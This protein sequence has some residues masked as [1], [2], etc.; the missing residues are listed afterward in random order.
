[1][2]ALERA[3]AAQLA[4]ALAA[5]ADKRERTPSVTPQ[6]SARAQPK[7]ID[8]AA[9]VQIS[10]YHVRFV[11]GRDEAESWSGETETTERTSFKCAGLSDA[12]SGEQA[13]VGRTCVERILTFT[14]TD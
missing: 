9:E 5:S 7:R 2:S 6:N 13:N 12:C 3:E 4:V 14:E 8:V 1:M 10:K 11:H